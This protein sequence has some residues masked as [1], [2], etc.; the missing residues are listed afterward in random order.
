MKKHLYLLLALIFSFSAVVLTSCDNFMNGS[1]ALDQ[2]EKIID[3]ANAKTY[4]ILV[5]QDTT[6]G[7]FLSS[8]DKECLVGY[9]IDLQYTVDSDNYIYNGLEAVSKV[10]QNNSRA[11]CVE[12]TKMSS[13]VDEKAGVYKVQVKLIKE[14]DDIMIRAKCT[15]IPK[16]VSITPEFTPSGYDQDTLVKITFNKAINPQTFENY[17]CVSIFSDSSDLKADFFEAPALTDNNTVLVFGPKQDKHIITP[18]SG[19]KMDI[20]VSINFNGEKDA[21]GIVITDNKTHSYRINESFGNQ[22]I[23]TL[24]VKEDEN[25]KTGFFDITGQIKC[26]VGYSVDLQFTVKKSDYVFVG[27]EAVSKTNNP[28]FNAEEFVDF[29]I[30]ENKSDAD[31]GIYTINV[32]V[33]KFSDDILIKPKCDP[34]PKVVSISPEYET[35]GCE[36][37]STISIEFNKPVETTEYFSPSITDASGNNLAE[38]FDKPYFSEDSKILYIPT[39]KTK[40]L[41]D[42]KG[43]TE[44]RDIIVK[45]DLSDFKD[46]D[47]NYGSGLY[48]YKYRVNKTLDSVKPILTSVDLYASSEMKKHLT[49]TAFENWNSTGTGFGDFGTNHIKDSVYIEVDGYDADSGIAGFIV[50]EKIIRYT[51]ETVV[52]VSPTSTNISCI[53]NE[54]TGKYYADYD[55]NTVY[56]GIIELEIFVEDYAGNCSEQSK[57]F[58]VLKDTMIDT[59]NI[60]F[61]QEA[62]GFPDPNASGYKEACEA[63]LASVPNVTGD[64]Q[65]VELSISETFANGKKAAQDYFYSNFYSPYEFSVYWGYS[66]EAATNEITKNSQNKYVFTRDVSKLVIIRVVCKDELGNEKEIIKRM[67]PRAEI[68]VG[69][70][71]DEIQLKNQSSLLIQ[72][73]TNTSTTGLNC[74]YNCIYEF[75]DGNKVIYSGTTATSPL[76]EWTLSSVCGQYYEAGNYP[77]GIVKVYLTSTIGDFP[78]PASLNYLS[79]TISSWTEDVYTGQYF[80]D[81]GTSEQEISSDSNAEITTVKAYGPE[82]KDYISRNPIKIKTTPITNS[83]SFKVV[84]DDYWTDEGKADNVDYSFYVLSWVQK[85]ATI[86]AFEPYNSITS[87]TPEIILGSYMSYKVYVMA[88]KNNTMYCPLSYSDYITVEGFLADNADSFEILLND[89]TTPIKDLILRK[90]V[91]PPKVTLFQNGLGFPGGFEI[92][93]PNDDVWDPFAE[94]NNPGEIGASVSNMFKNEEGKYEFT[95]YI[96][97]NP[98]NNIK[99]IPSYTLEELRTDYRRFV[100]TF[101]YV[102]DGWDSILSIPYGDLTEGFYTISFVVEDTN[103]NAAV[104]TYPFVKNVLGKLPYKLERKY[105]YIYYDEEHPENGGY[106]DSWLEFSIE[107]AKRDSL[108]I[109][110][111][112][113]DALKIV[114]KFEKPEYNGNYWEDDGY[115]SPDLCYSWEDVNGL[116]IRKLT[117]KPNRINYV[118]PM[119]QDS[120]PWRRIKAYYGFEDSDTSVGKGFYNLEYVFI[121]ENNYCDIKNCLDGL[122]GIQIF[123]NNSVLV[124]TMYSDSKLT[125]SKYTKNAIT[126]WETK[127]AETG[128]KT[129]QCPVNESTGNN[130]TLNVTYGLNNLDNIPTGCWYTT[131][132]HFADGTTVMTDIKQKY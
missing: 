130:E 61:E 122:N 34:V 56:D 128:L 67:V 42:V 96:I 62:I 37:D 7:S 1:E 3:V 30:L 55:L 117:F 127:G 9:T 68:S 90:D 27:L 101:E 84:I 10:N 78:S 112:G 59:T 40:R 93:A 12:F 38:Y 14:S 72:C 24:L 71:R 47:G 87:K 46:T 5:D 107:E 63:I 36:Q 8:G 75:S 110:K 111:N 33:K 58:Y 28:D 23:S 105:R 114:I 54:E 79:R 69:E 17:D 109:T 80:P 116:S 102:N 82:G 51:D 104:Y 48:Q 106:S 77:T 123:S 119:A 41:L 44:I 57:K 25:S 26:T 64:E 97:P 95:Y 99:L 45:L 115:I 125:D 92:I 131:I 94:S 70:T 103:G 85:D 4:I 120:N 49:P 18:D 29:A 74:Y 11:D 132:V 22:E 100:K 32:Y 21:E 20:T 113:E 126:T 15:Q 98:S 81:F 19:K 91:V 31:S 52:S 66:E 118:T 43:S 16:I 6:K 39:I 88:S 89:S 124:H 13:A 60:S 53:K 108:K 86:K 2:F 83:G 129:Y 50:K 121:G 35:G 73:K 76:S 65:T